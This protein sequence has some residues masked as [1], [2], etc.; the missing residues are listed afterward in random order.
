M[1]TEQ[2]RQRRSRYLVWAT[3]SVKAG[4]S[5]SVRRMMKPTTTTTTLRKNGIRHPQDSSCSLDSTAASG[6][7]T[8]LATIEPA[9]VPLRVKLL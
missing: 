8:A 1:I 9:W 4:V 2:D 7:N 5:S 3:S 6:K